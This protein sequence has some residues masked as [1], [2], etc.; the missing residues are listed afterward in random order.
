MMQAFIYRHL[1]PSH[2]FLV[3]VRGGGRPGP[4]V[5]LAGN[6]P[7]QIPVGGAAQVRVLTPPNPKLKDVKFELREPPDG[8]SIDGIEVESS[9]VS[10]NIKAAPDI[11][12]PGLED[13][14]I[15]EAFVE[16]SPPPKDVKGPKQPQR[17]SA[18]VL[19]A[20]PIEIVE[21]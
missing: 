11:V 3:A 10:F 9:G 14:L 20:I 19:P 21:Q 15:V 4:P 18:G 6:G 16:P 5:E 17:V 1:I 8:I 7:V 12:K 13:N 2:E